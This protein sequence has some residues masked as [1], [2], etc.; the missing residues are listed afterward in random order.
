MPAKAQPEFISTILLTRG[1]RIPS[2][3]FWYVLLKG[4]INQIDLIPRDA[5]SINHQFSYMTQ[6]M[7]MSILSSIN[8]RIQQLPFFASGH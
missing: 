5:W 7:N 8:G 6:S 1:D 3:S 4:T 2:I